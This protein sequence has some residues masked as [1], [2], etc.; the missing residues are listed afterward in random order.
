MK[1]IGIIGCGAIGSELAR[2]I[3][4]EFRKRAE[5]VALCDL[6]KE[7]ARRLCEEIGICVPICSIEETIKR[8]D[9][10]IESASAQVSAKIARRCLEERKEVMV[11]SS[12]GLIGREEI[13]KLAEQ[14]R[15]CLYIPSGALAGIDGAK[16]IGLG[17][18]Y[19]VS[20]ITRKP[21]KGLEGAPY[22]AQNK[23]DLSKIQGEQTIFEGGIEEAEKAFPRNINIAATLSLALTCKQITVKII[24][25]PDFKTNSHQL[26]IRG[27]CGELK[28]EAD[29]LPSSSN[30]RTSYLAILSAIATLEDILGY[31]RIGT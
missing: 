3:V 1:K 23:I 5:L 17:R 19:S 15:K 10:I 26:I 8:G 29:N 4:R 31:V 24:T 25:S 20:L 28:V 11:M 9:L 7:K 2:R 22:I 18:I 12:G 27:E 30:P 6:D 14:R 21:I 13:L 16:A